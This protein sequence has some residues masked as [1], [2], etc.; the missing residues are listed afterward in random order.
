MKYYSVTTETDLQTFVNSVTQQI[1]GVNGDWQILGGICVATI[2]QDGKIIPYYS[3]SFVRED[4][5]DYQSEV[6]KAEEANKVKPESI[7]L[8]E[9]IKTSNTL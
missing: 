8:I 5:L 1:N 2:I 4:G 6:K 9:E 7:P 3:Q